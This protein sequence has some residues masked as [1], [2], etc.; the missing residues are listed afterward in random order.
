MS[1]LIFL[2][3]LFLLY[4]SSRNLTRSIGSAIY[5]LTGNRD[6]TVYLMALLFL[7]GTLVH[8][9]SHLIMAVFL[10]VP[11]GVIELIPKVEDRGVI[12]GSVPI[13]NTDRVR[14]ALIGA[15]PFFVGVS[16][17]LGLSWWLTSFSHT[18]PELILA[19]YVSFQLANSCFASSRDME[20][21]LELLALPV[22]VLTVLYLVGFRLP[23]EWGLDLLTKNPEI[24]QNLSRL[25]VLPLGFNLLILVVLKLLGRPFSRA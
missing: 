6:L 1:L 13:G 7:P 5:R 9:L 16:A 4:L 19:Y 2:A 14:R 11:T 17:L 23:I 3:L 22:V 10:G 21:S 12:M 15:A 20:G 18:W 24:F 8:E 25:L